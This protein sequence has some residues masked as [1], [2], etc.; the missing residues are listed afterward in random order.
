[1]LTAQ[2]STDTRIW[3]GHPSQWINFRLY[4]ICILTCFLV[5]PLFI[6]AW[7]WLVTQCTRY[8]LTSQRIFLSTGVLNKKTD[9]LELYR[10]LDMQIAEPFFLRLFGLGNVILTTSDKTTPA[11]TFQAIRDPRALSDLL[12]KHVETCRVAKGTREIDFV[13]ND[14]NL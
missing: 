7:R 12:R 5:I 9:A 11:F 1:M 13:D 4:L 10:V 14:T 3:E 2:E 6:A 8:E